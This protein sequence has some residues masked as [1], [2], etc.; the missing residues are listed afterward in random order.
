MPHFIFRQADIL[1]IYCFFVFFYVRCACRSEIG[2][3][4]LLELLVHF[5]FLPHLSVNVYFVAATLKPVYLL[6]HFRAEE[7]VNG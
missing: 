7:S 3:V 2:L 6:A 4:C 1:W 5:L